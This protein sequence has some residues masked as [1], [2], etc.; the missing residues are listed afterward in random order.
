MGSRAPDESAGSRLEAPRSQL[1][2]RHARA[3]RLRSGLQGAVSMAGT[4]C[5]HAM[6][7][8]QAQ[9]PHVRAS[10]GTARERVS[11]ITPV[12]LGL[13]MTLGGWTWMWSIVSFWNPIAFAFMW[14]G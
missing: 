6:R 12:A 7:Q 9:E 1:E 4:I 11:R 8:V 2:A 14:T 10:F 3:A 13:A 5:H